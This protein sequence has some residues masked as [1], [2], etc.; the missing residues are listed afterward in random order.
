[1][2]AAVRSGSGKTIITC[3]MLEAIRKRGIDVRSY[4]CGPDY[5]DPM[6]HREAVGVPS[7]NLDPYFSTGSQLRAQLAQTDGL[8][9]V[10]GVM[11]YYDGVGTQ[12]QAR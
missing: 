3:G 5:I 7:K 12:G 10:E 1:M 9:V 4:K 2:I 11:G 8:A 6:F